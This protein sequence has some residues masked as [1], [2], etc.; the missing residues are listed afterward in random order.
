MTL[1]EALTARL[2]AHPGLTALI[3]NRFDWDEMP[4]GNT[5]YVVVQCISDV[6]LHTHDGQAKTEQP[7]YQ[8]T[9]YAATRA[10]ARAVAEQIKAAL[11]DY[12][13]TMSGLTIQYITLINELP[14]TQLIADGTVKVHTVALEFEIIYNRE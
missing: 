4:P 7:S 9:A 2:L 10:G 8:F 3:G 13:G 5:P 14:D 12:T 6:K 1:E 11:S